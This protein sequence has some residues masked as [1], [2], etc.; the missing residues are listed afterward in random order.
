M[1]RV[2]RLID[3]T[4]ELFRETHACPPSEIMKL[5]YEA[6]DE[7]SPEYKRKIREIVRNCSCTCEV[8][9]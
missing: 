7:T 5:L 1:K 3:T 4:Y 2:E 8:N 6:Y 9:L